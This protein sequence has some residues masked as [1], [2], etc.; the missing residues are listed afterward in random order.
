[1]SGKEIN[2]NEKYQIK[3]DSDD[4]VINS[5]DY[6]RNDLSYKGLLY[7]RTERNNKYHAAIFGE[8]VSGYCR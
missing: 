7:E 8:Q 5:R 2:L 4:Y 1:M 3:N 6:Y